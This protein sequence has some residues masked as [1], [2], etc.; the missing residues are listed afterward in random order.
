MRKLTRMAAIGGVGLLALTACGD[1]EPEQEETPNGEQE[2]VAG[3]GYE[4]AE[5]LDALDAQ[6]FVS[7][8]VISLNAGEYGPVDVLDERFQLD[9]LGAECE[10]GA[11]GSYDCIDAPISVK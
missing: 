11:E 4:S 3:G 8:N 6:A 10:E 7:N 1:D 9:P 5:D 2:E